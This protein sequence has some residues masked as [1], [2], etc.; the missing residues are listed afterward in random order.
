[1]TTTINHPLPPPFPFSPPSHS[2][3]PIR[4]HRS[5]ATLESPGSSPSSAASERTARARLFRTARSLGTA[6][7][8]QGSTRSARTA[9]ATAPP[10]PETASS[11][12]P[13]SAA[14]LTSESPRD[15]AVRTRRRARLRW[16]RWR[17]P[18]LHDRGGKSGPAWS[19][20]SNASNALRSSA[21]LHCIIRSPIH[22]FSCRIA[23][24]FSATPFPFPLYD[25]SPSKESH[26]GE[27]DLCC[28]PDPRRFP[29]SPFPRP[30][31][32]PLEP[33]EP[34]DA[35]ELLVLLVL[36]GPFELLGPLGPLGSL[37]SLGSFKILGSLGPFGSFKPLDSFSATDPLS[38][39]L[40]AFPASPPR[41]L[42]A[43]RTTAGTVFPR[44]FPSVVSATTSSM[45]IFTSF[46][47]MRSASKP[48]TSTASTLQESATARGGLVSTLS[49]MSRTTHWSTRRREEATWEQERRKR[50]PV[51]SSRCV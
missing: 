24:Q 26:S 10:C 6:Y 17:A 8:P 25:G 47:A 22:S 40:P 13:R 19:C 11:P 23:D 37:G 3:L 38:P 35:L 50:T 15:W 16:V 46:S 36:L 44:F 21:S 33:L 14:A 28:V 1:M 31:L 29:V 41:V 30:P 48:A 12:F 20:S 27:T 5:P 43:V 18:S 42:L 39:F 4:T 7:N 9:S 49:T 2:R 51:R 32:E 45:N 34:L